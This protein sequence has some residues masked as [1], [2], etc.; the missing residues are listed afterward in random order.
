[1]RRRLDEEE[2]SPAVVNLRQRRRNDAK[3]RSRVRDR[4][5]Q[6]LLA[7]EVDARSRHRIGSCHQRRAQRDGPSA[8]LPLDPGRGGQADG[9]Q[10][11]RADIRE[12]GIR[13]ARADA[14]E[15]EAA[16]ALEQV[17]GLLDAA[18]DLRCGDVGA[19]LR[20][21]SRVALDQRPRREETD[22]GH[23]EHEQHRRK[24]ARTQ[25]DLPGG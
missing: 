7:A 9:A 23:G 6:D 12:V 5:G 2:P 16:E 15:Q 3:Q 19:V 20:V 24:E 1:M 10:P 17:R 18:A 14:A 21:T 8:G 22:G 4:R 11:P 13:H 25:A